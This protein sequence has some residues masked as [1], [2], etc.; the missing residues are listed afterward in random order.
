MLVGQEKYQSGATLVS[1]R[2]SQQNLIWVVPERCSLSGRRFV[3]PT[4]QSV[5][6][7]IAG[8][9]HGFKTRR[10]TLVNTD[11]VDKKLATISAS[12]VHRGA[13]GF[14]DRDSRVTMLLLINWFR[15]LCVE[16]Q[17]IH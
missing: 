7:W 11:T 14:I 4:D 16:L 8:C 15:F 1:I 6:Q 9:L 5:Y 3:Q 10:K 12:F 17:N 2:E 13:S